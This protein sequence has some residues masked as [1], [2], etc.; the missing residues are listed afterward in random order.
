[1]KQLQ[2][3]DTAFVA[4]EQPNT[5]MH[6][7]SIAIYDP[8]T[9]PGGFVRFKDILEFVE[10]RMH[11][12][13]TMRQ[14]MVKVPFDIDYPY[15]IKDPKFDLE[16]HIRHAALPKPGDWRQLCIMASRT[17]ARPLD[18]SRPVWEL[19]VVEGLDNIEGIPKGSYAMVSKVHHSA[20]DG[21][22]GIEMMHALNSLTPDGGDVPPPT[23][24][25]RPDA[26]PRQMGLFAK[27]AIRGAFNPVRQLQVATSSAP[28]L[29]RMAR[30][31][32]KGDFEVTMSAPRT[33]FNG[34]ASPHR[35]IASQSFALDD[36]KSM[37]ALSDGATVNDVML[38]I[39]GGAM[40][41]YLQSKDE[42]PKKSLSAM[43][44]IS[45]RS[46]NEKKAMGN[47]VSAMRAPLGTDIED[48]KERLNFV[49][50]ETARS[51]AMTNAL[52]ARQMTEISKSSPALLMGVGA[53]LY[54]RLGLA[55]RIKPMFNTI[56]TNVPG[57]PI[58]LYSTGA[59]MVSLHG[60][61]CL[62]DG[63]LIG[64]VVQSYM[65]Q[66]T[67]TATACREAMPDPEFYDQCIQ[68]SH[69]ELLA[70]LKPARK[71]RKAAKRTT[72]KVTK[73]K[74]V[75]ASKRAPSKKRS[76]GA[77]KDP[78]NGKTPPRESPTQPAE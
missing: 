54:T 21:M 9:A 18:L 33:R 25:W 71:P 16:Y 61:V 74:T 5:P 36:I 48:A 52:G 31:A 43:A 42:L 32:A 1:M 11:L 28:G 34:K 26:M 30:G 57:P 17:F 55:N 68:E 8:S 53:R 62:I 12:A 6:I 65:G 13:K 78:R 3:L 77:V 29:Y 2:G 14:R 66:I 70:A 47:Q 75:A 23:E 51:K 38:A 4:F 69:D 15:W 46:E 20:I 19:W 56:V 39:V 27:G 73:K 64:H 67:L 37:R 58:P 45:V 41:K 72:K 50:A 49:R 35:V 22:S 59:Q 7:G 60:L 76:N 10:K 44:P 40:R 63:L 24:E